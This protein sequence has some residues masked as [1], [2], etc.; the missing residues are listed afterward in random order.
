MQ[1]SMEIRNYIQKRNIDINELERITGVK[2]SQLSSSANRPLN[3]GELL[4]IC[5][6]LNIQPEQMWK[7]SQQH[8]KIG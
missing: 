6:A 2:K 1:M 4:A 3:A 5:S 8:N 7:D